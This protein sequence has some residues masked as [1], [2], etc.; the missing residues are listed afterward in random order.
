MH[1]QSMVLTHSVLQNVIV[2]SI[3][4]AVQ[5]GNNQIMYMGNPYVHAAG[6]ELF[7]HA[8]FEDP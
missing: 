2:D 1:L 7:V 8:I 3:N 6:G 5:L 4:R